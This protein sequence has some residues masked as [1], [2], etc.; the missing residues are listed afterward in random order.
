MNLLKLF[1][2]E[3]QN[4]KRAIESIPP[5]ELSDLWWNFFLG[6]RKSD[7]S[8]YEANT[9][10]T[11]I[12]IFDRHLRRMK[13]GKQIISSLEFSKVREVL[14]AKQKDLKNEGRG[15]IS[16]KSDKITDEE[17]NQLWEK[18]LLGVNNS[19][20]VINSLWLFSTIFLES[21]WPV[22]FG[23]SHASGLKVRRHVLWASFFISSF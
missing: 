8:N 9:W 11:F 5:P 7:G 16:Q 18:E 21:W 15:D 13:Y 1:L 3:T 2:D 20:S 22:L 6:V 17:I 19:E 14:K 12:Y 23:N 4:E 10:R